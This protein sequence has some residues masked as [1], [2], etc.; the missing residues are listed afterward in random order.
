MKYFIYPRKNQFLKSMSL[1]TN[2]IE[3]TNNIDDIKCALYKNIFY[4]KSNDTNLIPPIL[5]FVSKKLVK[6]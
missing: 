2:F 4:D 1:L 5:A 6:V 3:K